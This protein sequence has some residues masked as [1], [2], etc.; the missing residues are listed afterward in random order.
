MEQILPEPLKGSNPDGTLIFNAS[1]QICE[2]VHFVA[3]PTQFVVV[4]VDLAK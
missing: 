2:I 1:F 4:T 3:S